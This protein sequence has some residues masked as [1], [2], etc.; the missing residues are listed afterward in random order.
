M[1]VCAGL[2]KKATI[3]DPKYRSLNRDAEVGSYV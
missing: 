1:R 2:G 3:T